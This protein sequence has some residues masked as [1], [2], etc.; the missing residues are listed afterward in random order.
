MK[1]P[2]KHADVMPCRCSP[3]TVWCV[4]WSSWLRGSCVPLTFTWRPTACCTSATTSSIASR[5]SASCLRSEAM[6]GVSMPEWPS[7]SQMLRHMFDAAVTNSIG[8][9]GCICFFLLFSDIYVLHCY[10]F[11]ACLW[12]LLLGID[13]ISTR[14]TAVQFDFGLIYNLTLILLLFD[15]HSAAYQRS[16]R[17]QWRITSV[18]LHL[19]WVPLCHCSYFLL[20]YVSKMLSGFSSVT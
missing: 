12:W 18:F 15:L 10:S 4:V 16:L 6:Q 7:F 11:V 13:F 5:C 17:P 8:Y 14:S 9:I 19:W 1:R 2:R 20:L 3:L